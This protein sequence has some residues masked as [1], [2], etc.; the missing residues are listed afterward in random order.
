MWGPTWRRCVS[1]RID[2]SSPQGGGL[3][4]VWASMRRISRPPDESRRAVR[5]SGPRCHAGDSES[6]VMQVREVQAVTRSSSGAVLRW[7]RN[8]HHHAINETRLSTSLPIMFAKPK[9]RTPII[10]WKHTLHLEV[11]ISHFLTQ[12]ITYLDSR[13]CIMLIGICGG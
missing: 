9:W 10:C 2:R 13:T 3:V 1:R 5:Q 8:E 4:T 7:R 6:G 11:F 12:Q